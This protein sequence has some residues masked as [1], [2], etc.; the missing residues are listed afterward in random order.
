[1]DKNHSSVLTPWEVKGDVKYE[2]LMKQFGISALNQYLRS[3]DS[4]L[5]RRN[6]I[7]A[8]RDFAVIDKAIKD[9]KPFTMMTGCMP[10]GKFHF[11][12]MI[13]AEHFLLYQKLGAKVF[14]AV[15]DIEAYNAQ[16][17]QSQTAPSPDELKRL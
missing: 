12:H 14:L 9:K 13:V 2:K 8:Q 11:G 15:A 7:F 10:T 17:K 3:I 6:K 1:M 4:L 16:Q 5:I